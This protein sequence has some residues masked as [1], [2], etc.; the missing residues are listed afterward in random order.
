[1]MCQVHVGLYTSQ[2]YSQGDPLH[3][4]AFHLTSRLSVLYEILQLRNARD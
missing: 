1:M 3:V 4:Y 2:N